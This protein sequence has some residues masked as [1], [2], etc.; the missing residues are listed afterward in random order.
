V[1][2]MTGTEGHDRTMG[3]ATCRNSAGP[4]IKTIPRDA[5]RKRSAPPSAWPSCVF[6]RRIDTAFMRLSRGHN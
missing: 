5:T 2:V 1:H 4:A 6:R 3:A